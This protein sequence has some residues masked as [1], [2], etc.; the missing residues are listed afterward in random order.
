[1][2]R[3]RVLH[4]EFFISLLQQ[5][6]PESRKAWQALVDVARGATPAGRLGKRLLLIRNKVFF[7]YDQKAIFAGY[8]E[9]FLGPRKQDDR[10]YVSRGQSMR[11]TRFF[12][13]DGAVTGYLSAVMGSE[14]AGALADEI[15]DIIVSINH[16][17]ML[18]VGQFIQR[19]GYSFRQE[20]TPR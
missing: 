17:L 14:T 11:A 10:A 8:A 1:M 20:A 6:H 13:A 12:F 7:H 16:G 4:H 15:A 2:A 9:H 18:I 19:R 5:V 3:P